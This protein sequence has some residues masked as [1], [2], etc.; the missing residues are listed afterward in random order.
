MTNE[1]ENV[2]K[3][4][5]LCHALHYADNTNHIMH[6][7]QVPPWRRSTSYINAVAKVIYGDNKFDHVTLLLRDKLHWLRITERV[8]YKLC[9]LTYKALHG[10]AL[11][12]IADF[13]K[14]VTSITP[15]NSLRPAE[16]GQLL[17]Q[18]SRTKFGDQSFSVAVPRA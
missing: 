9:L 15:W 7:W 2:G 3:S 13:W 11:R 10:L 5:N 8:S 14:P 17:V 4:I 1:Q 18:R 6:C 12:Y 16:P